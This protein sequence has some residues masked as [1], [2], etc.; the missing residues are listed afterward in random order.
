[1]DTIIKFICSFAKL[2]NDTIILETELPFLEIDGGFIMLNPTSNE[3]S[4]VV[5]RLSETNPLHP[6]NQSS[7]IGFGA[8]IRS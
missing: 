7:Y 4:E 6:V 1:M 2:Y 5:N 8:S 3:V